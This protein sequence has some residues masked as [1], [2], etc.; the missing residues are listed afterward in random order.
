MSIPS[1]PAATVMQDFVF[2]GI[3]SDP[4]QLLG[5][6]QRRWRGIRHF[7]QST[8]LDPQ[9]GEAVTLTVTVGQDVHVDR[10]SAYVTLD[11]SD[12]VGAR[13]RATHGFSVDLT[14]VDTLWQPLIWD[15]VDIW[16]G[17]I[18][19]QPDGTLVH[20]RIEGWHS[21]QTWV[22]SQ[23]GPNATVWSSEMNL[24]RS[25]EQA[26]LYGYHVD[27]Y[28]TPAWVREAVIYQI[29]VDRFASGP[30]GSPVKQGWLSE[31]EMN[32]FMGGN[33][34]GITARLDYIAELGVTALWLTP[35]FS[36]DAYHA[37]DTLDY[38]EI[39]P[40]F[41]TKADL[42]ALVDAAHARGL[43]V[44]L[45]FVANHTS[46]A[47]PA[48]QAALADTASPYREWF[49]FDPAYT[50]GY[51]CFFDVAS[52]PQFNVDSRAVRRYLCDAAQYWLREFDVDGYRLDYAAGPS[53]S[54]W[55]E[56]GAAC[57][58]IKPDCWLF[59]EVTRLGDLLR[60]YAG[61]LDGCL[62][63]GFTRTLRQI[64]NGPD[65]SI[66]LS[67]FVTYVER[68]QRFYPDG[69]TLPAFLDN[70]DMNRFLWVVGN[71]M[72]RLRMALGLLFGF[73]GTPI[74]YYGT[75][76]GLSQPHPKRPYMEE[77]RHPMLWA[78]QDRDLLAYTQRL[79][80]LRKT[81]PALTHGEFQTHFLDDDLGLWLV[82]RTNGAD[83]VYIAVNTG[84]TA[85][86][87]TL[88]AGTFTDLIRGRES[89]RNV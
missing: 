38:W 8:P 41:G 30:T 15:Y 80:A 82:E 26:T 19:E 47:S 3:E 53:H 68:T 36:A 50:H 46:S 21:Q 13:G 33:L 78:D 5:V 66:P 51:R 24:D 42:R 52:M 62:D 1:S 7:H 63:F 45:D 22:G 60:S 31:D 32:T 11:G 40:R 57:K 58:A 49:S 69:F 71:D 16:R 77:S 29:F 14:R 44:I 84:S 86:T 35:I 67:R 18:P 70:H 87:L 75:E 81:H 76:V 65:A 27:R 25:P 39:D 89:D 10:V 23:S 48:F 55:S 64:C 43:R 61:R 28:Q 12:P 4:D 54:F 85:Q 20:Y 79:I 74:L 17:E 73:G 88:P 2:G 34:Q 83:G 6:E 72:A 9:P 37:Y 56:F 59:G